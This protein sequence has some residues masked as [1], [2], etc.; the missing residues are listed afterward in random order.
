MCR[1][2]TLVVLERTH[3]VVKLR[4]YYVNVPSSYNVT[5]KLIQVLLGGFFF[6][7]EQ[8]K[9]SIFRVRVG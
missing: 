2:Y 6:N 9:K 4:H 3:M 7:G 8:V 5:S 1:L